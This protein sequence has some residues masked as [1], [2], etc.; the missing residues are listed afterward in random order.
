VSWTTGY[1]RGLVVCPNG[2]TLTRTEKLV[3]FVLA[4]SHEHNKY[5]FPSVESI[6]NNALMSKQ[7]CEGVLASLETKGIILRVDP[8]MQYRGVAQKTL[9]RIVAGRANPAFVV[10]PSLVSAQLDSAGTG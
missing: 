5:A 4:A 7:E 10:G 8:A 2:E 3:A 1:I 9:V 6:A